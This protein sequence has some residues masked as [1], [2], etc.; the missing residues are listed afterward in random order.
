GD[1]DFEDEYQRRIQQVS[2][3][4]VQRVA[5]KYLVPEAATVVALAPKGQEALVEPAALVEHLC[6]G[7]KPKAPAKRAKSQEMGLIKLPG[8]GRVVMVPDRTN[9]IVAVRCTW[10]G[11]L[12]T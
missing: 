1:A 10:L 12:R 9:P 7:L 6:A 11:G 8:G 3:D 2:A 5:R 4:D